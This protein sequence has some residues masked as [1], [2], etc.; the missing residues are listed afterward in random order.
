VVCF[1]TPPLPRWVAWLEYTVENTVLFTGRGEEGCWWERWRCCVC[2]EMMNRP[3]RDFSV[4]RRD[5]GHMDS[6][7]PEAAAPCCRRAFRDSAFGK[8]EA[9]V[10]S[11]TCISL[12]RAL[13]TEPNVGVRRWEGARPSPSAPR[14]HPAHGCRGC[15]GRGAGGNQPWGAGL[16]TRRSRLHWQEISLTNTCL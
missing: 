5:A 10:P 3:G 13:R 12:S 1:E 2:V 8:H 4:W 6:I 15:T 11:P 14:K 16:T 7:A 9:L